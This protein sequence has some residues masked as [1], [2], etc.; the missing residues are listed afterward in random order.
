MQR[1][2]SHERTAVDLSKLSDDTLIDE[3]HALVASH[4]RATSALIEHLGEM[5]ARRLHVEKGF[6]S[7]FSYCVERLRFSEDEACRRIE[8]A[9]LARRFPAVLSLLE[10]GAVG[11][12]F[13]EMGA[14]GAAPPSAAIGTK[15]R[16]GALRIMDG[17]SG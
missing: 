17:T 14:R 13:V 5:D 1:P 4:R 6:S 16:S 8:A 2:H 15:G 12:P 9:R 3:L 7:L 10:A 11:A